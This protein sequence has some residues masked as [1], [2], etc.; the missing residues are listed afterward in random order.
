MGA[1]ADGKDRGKRAAE[2]RLGWA[3]LVVAIMAVIFSLSVGPRLRGT[4]RAQDG[5]RKE[6]DALRQELADVR[7]DLAQARAELQAERQ[8][9]EKEDATAS[10]LEVAETVGGAGS[11]QS[12]REAHS[13]LA[14][15]DARQARLYERFNR[16]VHDLKSNNVDLGITDP[17]P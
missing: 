5:L 6:I 16:L 14:I 10:E 9:A 17:G 7:Q 12:L 2:A 11:L 3:A 13:R 1:I 15:I 4:E 8:E